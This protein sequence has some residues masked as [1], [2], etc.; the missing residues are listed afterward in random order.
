[1]NS[2]DQLYIKYHK[3]NNNSCLN[4][5]QSHRNKIRTIIKPSKIAICEVNQQ[6]IS[7]MS[8][9]QYEFQV[10]RICTLW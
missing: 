2:Q 3:N 4:T 5:T 10:Q 6:N 1:M 8:P 7:S 9:M